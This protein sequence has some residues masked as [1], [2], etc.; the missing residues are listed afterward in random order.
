[1]IR[2]KNSSQTEPCDTSWDPKIVMCKETDTMNVYSTSCPISSPSL[3]FEF[4]SNCQISS[5]PDKWFYNYLNNNHEYGYEKVWSILA[6]EI[7]YT[8]DQNL[9]TYLEYKPT[10]LDGVDY[11]NIPL[12]NPDISN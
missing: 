6:N 2:K 1:M 10:Q 9:Y 4:D 11:T 12:Y 8:I 5:T 7:N 3:N